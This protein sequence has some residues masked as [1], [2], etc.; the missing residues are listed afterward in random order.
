MGPSRQVNEGGFTLLEL[1]IAIMLLAIGFLATFT[2]IWTSQKAGVSS[3]NIT[4]AAALGQDL[5]EQLAFRN[6]TGLKSGTY[7]FATTAPYPSSF[8]RSYTIQQD[9]PGANMK[10]ITATVSWTEAGRAKTRSFTTVR[11]VEF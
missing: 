11:R 5:M 4:S 10:T 6:Y 1:M 8:S 9:I 3:R 2:T 7:S